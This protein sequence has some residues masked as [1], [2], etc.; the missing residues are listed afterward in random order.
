MNIKVQEINLDI[1]QN[2]SQIMNQNL[3]ELLI[4]N[5]ITQSTVYVS[6]INKYIIKW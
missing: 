1:N 2:F 3:S 5:T 6:E 4:A